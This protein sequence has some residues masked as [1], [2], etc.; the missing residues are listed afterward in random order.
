MQIGIGL[1]NPVPG[2][3]GPLFAQW[4]RRAE[5]RGFSGLVTI[6][7]IVYPSVDSLTALAVAAGA[8]ERIGLMTNILLGPV[9]PDVLLAKT[10][11]S[12]DQLSGG[13]FTLGVGVGG[14]ADDFEVTG[15][16][17]G[18]RGK[19]LDATVETMHRAW[20]GET[21]GDDQPITPTPTRGGAVPMLFGGSG[22][23]GVRRTVRWGAG[24]TMG[25]GTPDRAAGMAQ[26]VRAAWHDA[27]REGEPRIAALAYFSLG[28]E[29]TESSRRYLLDYYAGLGDWA[30]TIADG[31]HRSVQAIRDTVKAFEDAGVTE[32]YLDPTV[33]SLDQV[34]RL[35]D[36]VL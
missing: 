20:S 1:P 2:A 19:T 29:H 10:A 5:E 17:F 6:D 11:A 23:A 4:A 28:G 34:D 31:A 32:L 13:R 16:D 3:P 21:F 14:R 15:R 24:W 8:T 36:V 35:A 33:A 18:A 12:L 25:G 9:Y 26:K 30:A 27:G 7:R 22:A